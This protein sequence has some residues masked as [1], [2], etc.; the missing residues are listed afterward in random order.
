MACSTC[1]ST[2]SNCT[3]PTVAS[4]Y[5]E[6]CVDIISTECVYYKGNYSNCLGLVKNF[7]LDDFIE[8]TLSILCSLEGG[9][10]AEDQ[11]LKSTSTI[12]RNATNNSWRFTYAFPNSSNNFNKDI[13]I[14]YNMAHVAVESLS[15]FTV[16][17]NTA[18]EVSLCSNTD[19]YYYVG[20]GHVHNGNSSYVGSKISTANIPATPSVDGN[21]RANRQKVEGTIIFSDNAEIATAYI[22]HL[23]IKCQ[24]SATSTTSTIAIVPF[25]VNGA[26]YKQISIQ[27]ITPVL[28][29]DSTIWME[30]S[31]EVETENGSE[32]D[33]HIHNGNLIVTE[34]P[35][36]S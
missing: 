7:R 4:T 1:T 6:T 10:S 35:S 15:S 21:Q 32:I 22:S 23:K 19:L 9:G 36:Q 13:T 17:S 25:T 33:L 24:N 18:A 16:S 12:I 14:T 29:A 3:P 20:I 31:N 27:G 30:I 8:K 28:P 34:I 2:C 11:Y 5:C 26:S